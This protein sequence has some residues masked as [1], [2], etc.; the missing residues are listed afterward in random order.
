MGNYLEIARKVLKDKKRDLNIQI[1]EPYFL[2][3]G[4]LCIPF[5]ADKKYQWWNGGM[6]VSGIK[7][8]LLN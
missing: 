5:N 3:N 2:K 6:S 1:P 4:D 7:K 8:H